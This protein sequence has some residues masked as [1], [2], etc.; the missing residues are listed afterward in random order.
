[1]DTLL[2][3]PAEPRTVLGKKVKNLRRQGLVPANMY[4]SGIESV[5]IQL[6]EKMVSQ[7]IARAS[8]SS[9]FSLELDGAKSQTVLVKH[10]QRHPTSGRV[11]HVD[12]FQVNMSEK[13]RATVPLHFVGEAPAVRRTGG[14][15]MHNLTTIEVESLPSDLPSS[16]EVDVS[17]LTRLDDLIHVSDLQVSP[18]VDVLTPGD[19]TVAK[20]LAPR[21][22]EEGVE[23]AAEEAVA[24]AEAS[25][26]GAEA[27]ETQ[28]S[29]GETN[30]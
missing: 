27:E 1:L 28:A 11:L 24:E 14:T 18:G 21:V 8:G 3:V 22:E 19:E 15:L 9:L 10:V 29:A 26:A 12:F 23:E 20:V 13:L 17:S 4:G 16:I 2:K 7:R 6:P 30:E 5:A 25:E